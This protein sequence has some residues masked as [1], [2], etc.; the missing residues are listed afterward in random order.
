MDRT[1]YPPSRAWLVGIC[2]WPAFLAAGIATLLFFSGIDPETLRLQT[3]PNWEISRTAG[4]SIG[5]LMFWA[6]AALSSA[7]S[8]L[9]ARPPR[10]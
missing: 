10:A 1:P 4:Y 9:L 2:L 5:F 7:V 8:V 3:V 6:V